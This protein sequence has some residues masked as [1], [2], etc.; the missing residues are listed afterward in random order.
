MLTDWVNTASKSGHLLSSEENLF[1][2]FEIKII[3]FSN[4]SDFDFGERQRTRYSYLPDIDNIDSEIYPL[5][6]LSSSNIMEE[7][8]DHHLPPWNTNIIDDFD[9]AEVVKQAERAIEGGILPVRISAGSSGSYFI[10]NLEG[11]CFN[12]IKNIIKSS[13]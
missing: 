1:L 11:V 7:L 5:L 2:F 4:R 13:F 12:F 9:Y 6:P 3:S 8:D 10:R